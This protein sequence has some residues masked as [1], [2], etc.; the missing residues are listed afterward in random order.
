MTQAASDPII[1]RQ[2]QSINVSGMYAQS[3]PWGMAQHGLRYGDGVVF[4]ETAGHGGF[5][6][7]AARNAQVPTPL[8]NRGGWYEED[9]EGLK[10]VAVFPELFGDPATIGERLDALLRASF[11]DAYAEWKGVTVTAAES[12][13]VARR[14]MEEAN[15]DGWIVTAAWGDWEDTVPAEMVGVV[16]VPVRDQHSSNREERYFLVSAPEYRAR[17]HN[18][19]FV[20]PARHEAWEGPVG[21]VTTKQ[22]GISLG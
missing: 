17:T 22:V 10:V 21:Q 5:K 20:D 1:T 18:T 19:F 11:P 4:Y 6:L 15:S 14:E 13:I 9:A 7:D 3:T 2:P 12:P 16:A 8:R